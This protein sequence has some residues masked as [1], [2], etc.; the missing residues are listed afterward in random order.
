MQRAVGRAAYQAFVAD[1]FTALHA[2]DGLE[3]R[4]QLAVL[5]DFL[6]ALHKMIRGLVRFFILRNI[7]GDGCQVSLLGSKPQWLG[8]GAG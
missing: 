8:M 7:F 4:R 3:Q 6:Q 1:D 2:D 5:Y